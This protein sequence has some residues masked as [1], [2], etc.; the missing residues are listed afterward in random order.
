[1]NTSYM[2]SNMVMFG[3]TGSAAPASFPAGLYWL[4]S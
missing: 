4:V 3:H 1:M 2:A